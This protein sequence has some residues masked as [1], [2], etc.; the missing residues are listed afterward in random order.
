M[1]KSIK[2]MCCIC[3]KVFN[4]KNPEDD[5]RRNDINNW[6]FEPHDYSFD[7]SHSYC[8]PC[9]EKELIKIG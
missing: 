7:Y 2:V 8:P 6:K 3:T 5:E 4:G 9:Y 1:S